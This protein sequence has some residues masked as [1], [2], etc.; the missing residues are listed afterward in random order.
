MTS[1][2]STYSQSYRPHNA[3]AN[4]G[5]GV[6]GPGNFD[7]EEQWGRLSTPPSDLENLAD[8]EKV[9]KKYRQAVFGRLR[10]PN[11]DAYK[12]AR[13]GQA[14]GYFMPQLSGDGGNGDPQSWMSLTQLQYERMKL[15]KPLEKWDLADALHTEAALEMATGSPFY[16]GIEIS[17]NVQDPDTYQDPKMYSASAPNS[18]L[19][20]SADR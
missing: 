12:V 4:R 11:A 5:H 3:A 15:T 16:P 14:S 8:D 2:S 13:N 18:S 19:V 17:R 10:L 9:D 7:D 20:I 6:G 1:A